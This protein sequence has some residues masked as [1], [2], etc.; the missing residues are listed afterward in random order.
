MG[1]KKIIAKV[2]FECLKYLLQEYI[3]K[4]PFIKS[5]VSDISFFT[6]IEFCFDYLKLDIFN[7]DNEN[8]IMEI[9]EENIELGEQVEKIKDVL[10][11]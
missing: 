6:T 10:R 8:K 11:N 2:S 3:D 7:N 4:K 5:L 1:K 9:M